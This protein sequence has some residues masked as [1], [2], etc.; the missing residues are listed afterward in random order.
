MENSQK[1][2]QLIE[3]RDADTIM[4]DKDATVDEL[5]TVTTGDSYHPTEEYVVTTSG[6]SFY[7]E[8]GLE[9]KNV[10]MGL[11]AVAGV[12]LLIAIVVFF[13]FI[14]RK[15][16]PRGKFLR[17]IKEF[18]NFRKV[19]IAGILK[20]IYLFL[21]LTLTIGCI[22]LMFFGG[23]NALKMIILCLFMLVF[24]NVSLRIGFEMTM[25]FIGL[26]NNTNDIRAVLVKDEEE[27]EK[28][29]EEPEEEIEEV[30]EEIEE[31]ETEE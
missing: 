12:S 19:W 24:G 16:A 7:D 8:F 17:K 30:E 14:I 20:F 11:L 6:V 4:Q 23:A 31:E 13:A 2:T 10:E 18:L 27:P 9:P 1:T 5:M 28:K 21:A 29:V 15:K 25:I 26:W 22:T 3:T